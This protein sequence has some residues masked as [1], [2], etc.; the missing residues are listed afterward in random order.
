MF[1][2]YEQLGVWKKVVNV[3]DLK[4]EGIVVVMDGD[5]DF[6]TSIHVEDVSKVADNRIAVLFHGTNLGMEIRDDRTVV[7]HDAEGRKVLYLEMKYAQE[8]ERLLE[9]FLGVAW[10][11]RE[12]HRHSGVT[13]EYQ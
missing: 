9:L 11:N 4:N 6:I 3:I 2:K 1:E 13:I 12:Y 10:R 8:T 7:K 5:S